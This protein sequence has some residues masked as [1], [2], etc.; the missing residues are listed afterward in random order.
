M[1]MTSL[2]L[3]DLRRDVPNMLSANAPVF[4]GVWA[5]SPRFI[6]TQYMYSLT[7]EGRWFGHAVVVR[8]RLLCRSSPSC[9]GGARAGE[10]PGGLPAGDRDPARRRRR[11][12][13]AFKVDMGARLSHCEVAAGPPRAAH[14]R[15]YS[16]MSTKDKMVSNKDAVFP[17]P[18]APQ[19]VTHEAPSIVPISLT[20]LSMGQAPLST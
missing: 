16:T 6:D 12:T 18:A 8:R 14:V 13:R 20:Q 3:S 1:L 19:P 15:V 7:V 10:E 2:V 17:G 5:L 11:R 9:R 4:S